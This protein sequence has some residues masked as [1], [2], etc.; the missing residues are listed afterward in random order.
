MVTDITTTRRVA[1]VEQNGKRF[2]VETQRGPKGFWRKIQ[3]YT[4]RL[5]NPRQR[6]LYRFYNLRLPAFWDDFSHGVFEPET[7]CVFDAFLDAEHSYIDI[8]AWIGPTVLYG[9]QLAR[10]CYAIEPDPVAYKLLETNVQLNPALCQKVTLFRGCIAAH[11]GVATLGNMFSSVGGDTRGSLVYSGVAKG[12]WNVRSTTLQQFMEVHQIR[13][14]NF[15]KMDVEGGESIIVPSIADFLVSDKPTLHLSLHPK[16][17]EDPYEDT[18]EI[19]QI[20]A[21]YPYL[22]DMEGKPIDPEKLLKDVDSF[23]LGDFVI[24]TARFPRGWTV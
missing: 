3:Y 22:L 23:R 16:Y 18:K 10:H 20:L 2:V 6:R 12:E 21:H 4:Q 1:T 11:C 24:A 8:G 13:D 7:L 14:C 17:F 15:I 19:L 9:C 5:L